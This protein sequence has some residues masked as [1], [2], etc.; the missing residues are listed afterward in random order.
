MDRHC[1]HR[2][3]ATGQRG[4]SCTLGGMLIGLGGS[5]S[6]SVSL[7]C[8]IAARLDRRHGAEQRPRVG[9]P[10]IEEDRVVIG[11]LHDAPEIHD[12]DAGADAPH[13]RKI[14]RDEDIGEAV[15]RLEALEQFEQAR[16]LLDL[17]QRRKRLVEYQQLRLEDQRA[18]NVDP[19]RAARRS[20][21][22][23]H[24]RR[25]REACPASSMTASV[26][27]RSSF[28]LRTPCT[29][30]RFRNRAADGHVCGGSAL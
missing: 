10:R 25:A 19:L 29:I 27:S 30:E 16:C 5:P 14:V 20:S 7:L 1:T 11:K 8:I 23:A 12:R 22:R 21:P 26:R 13:H 9:M 24:C 28:R 2:L 17:V 15:R 3:N 6:S 4:G 18:R